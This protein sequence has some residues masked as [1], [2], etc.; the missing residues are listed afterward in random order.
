MTPEENLALERLVGYDHLWA[1]VKICWPWV[2]SEPLVWNWHMQLLCD[3]YEA[4]LRG[5]IPSLVVNVPP[6]CSKSILTNVFF[7]A[8]AWV[9]QPG[10]RWIMA[11]GDQTLVNRDARMCLALMQSKQFQARWGNR[12][13]FP[14]RV[15]AIEEIHNTALG[16]RLGTTPGGKAIGWH[17]HIQV[18]DDLVKPQ[19]LT[20]VVLASVEEWRTSTMSQRWLKRPA[21]NCRILIAQRLH[22]DDPPGHELEDGALHV[23]IPMEF[24]PDR[25]CETKYGRD[26]RTERGELL[27]SFRFPREDVAK[28]RLALRPLAASAQLDQLPSPKGGSIF[29]ASHFARRWT[30]LPSRLG[31]VVF[32]VD[33]SFKDLA[34]SDFVVVQLWGRLGADFYLVDQVRGQW[35]FYQTLDMIKAF[36]A[37]YRRYVG[38]TIVEDKANGSAVIETLI[39]T[40]PGV[41]AVNPEGGKESRASA[42]SPFFEAGNI[43]LPSEDW[44]DLD[45]V[46]E[47]VKFPRGRKDDQVDCT[48]QALLHMHQ[49]AMPWLGLEK[50]WTGS[51]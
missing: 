45:Y 14:G 44:V 5:E 27:D 15:Q 50:Y 48:T 38:A 11:S 28:A 39:K 40:V 19:E 22:E 51:I 2:S 36:K 3:H 18:F 8:W 33:C 37:R 13:S 1:F 30:M 42:V 32:S 35:G 34:T 29:K 26:P 46:P 31:N 43:V 25:R 41:L 6:G 9:R 16:W 10:L 47:F 20:P 23:M 17:A 24:D 21:M 4:C 7:P 12:V 49:H